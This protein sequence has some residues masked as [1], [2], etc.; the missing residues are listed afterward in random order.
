[1]AFGLRR[2]GFCSRRDRSAKTSPEHPRRTRGKQSPDPPNAMLRWPLFCYIQHSAK[3]HASTTARDPHDC[4]GTESCIQQTR[5]QATI[6]YP[7]AS[8]HENTRQSMY[9]PIDSARLDVSFRS[10]VSFRVRFRGPTESQYRK[11]EKEPR[12]DCGTSR[13]RKEALPEAVRELSW[14]F[15]AG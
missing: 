15:R 13:E 3:Q 7:R 11:S 2:P 6:R 1:M 12:A 9:V 8:V 10:S 5:L 14:R 4:A